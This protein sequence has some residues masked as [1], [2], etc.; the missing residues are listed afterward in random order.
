M[1]IL[2]PSPN[3]VGFLTA[4]Y[5]AYYS[6]RDAEKISANPE[7]VTLF[8]DAVSTG[9]DV[10]LARKVREGIIIK[11]GEEA[12][13][14]VAA[15]Y[16]SGDKNKEEIIF[17]YLRLLFKRGRDVLTMYS[18]PVVIEFRDLLNKVTNEAHRFKGFLRFME[19]QEGV[20]YSYFGGDNDIIELLVPHFRARFN[21]Q[22]FVL[23]DI[24]RGKI[25]LWDGRKIYFMPA[26]ETVNVTLSENEI[27]FGALWKEYH[28]NVAISEREN[29]KLQRQFLPKKYR[30]FMNEF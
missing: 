17:R 30:W 3:L 23:H 19:T 12:Y 1:K 18:D 16:L 10:G 11:A 29:K 26:P 20:L 27:L 2:I 21:D 15:A 4:V 7:A 5:H 25:A 8:D 22:K 9:E 6:H 13:D 28:K 24:K 14:E